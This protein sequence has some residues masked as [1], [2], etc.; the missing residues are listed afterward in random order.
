MRVKRTC[1]LLA[2]TAVAVVGVAV[3]FF[4]AKGLGSLLFPE[5]PALTV[6]HVVPGLLIA[7]LMAVVLFFEAYRLFKA[8][9]VWKRTR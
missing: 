6:R 5:I 2:G 3:L 4:V 8:A 9:A 1:A 7:L